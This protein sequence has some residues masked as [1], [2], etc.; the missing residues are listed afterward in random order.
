M[1]APMGRMAGA[2]WA[3]GGRMVGAAAWIDVQE[4]A[5]LPADISIEPQTCWLDIHPTTRMP[6][7][8]IDHPLNNKKELPPSCA[9]LNTMKNTNLFD[10]FSVL[11]ERMSYR[12]SNI[13]PPRMVWGARPWRHC[14]HGTRRR[15]RPCQRAERSGARRRGRWRRRGRG[16]DRRK[17]TQAARPLRTAGPPEGWRVT[18]ARR[19]S[20]LDAITH[21]QKIY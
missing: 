12:M 16:P 3:Q 7:K 15:Q 5:S 17:G 19:G 8:T 18:E 14:R 6:N 1:G 13:I 4:P 2:W 11:R 21:P 20:T 9:S 10:S